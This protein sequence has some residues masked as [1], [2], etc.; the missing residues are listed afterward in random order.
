VTGGIPRQIDHPTFAEVY[1]VEEIGEGAWRA[2]FAGRYK[3]LWN[4]SGRHQ[5]FDLEAD[6]D[7]LHN[8]ARAEPE[9]VRKMAQAITEFL[10]LQPRPAAKGKREL[11]DEETRRALKSLGYLE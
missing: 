5:L 3:L 2:I 6:P 9:R 8:L 10:E 11:V 7:E 1:P 4:S